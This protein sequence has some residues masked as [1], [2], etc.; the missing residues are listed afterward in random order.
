[1]S[2]VEADGPRL[3]DTLDQSEVY[4]TSSASGTGG[5]MI[6]L[7]RDCRILRRNDVDIV[8]KDPALYPVGYQDI[9]GVCSNPDE[10]RGDA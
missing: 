10:T 8:A 1:M 7:D 9:C 4:C 6:H 5:S 2:R 3:T